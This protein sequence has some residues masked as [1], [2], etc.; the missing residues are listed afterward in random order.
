LVWAIR[1]TKS[2]N[3][4][5]GKLDKPVAKRIVNYMDK[6]IAPIVSDNDGY[7]LFRLYWSFCRLFG[8]LCLWFRTEQY[9]Q[10]YSWEL[11]AVFLNI[12]ITIFCMYIV[13]ILGRW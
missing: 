9:S 13:F 7:V 12:D 10:A 2:A 8:F 6:H 11:R 4:E 1:Y 5:L 3:K